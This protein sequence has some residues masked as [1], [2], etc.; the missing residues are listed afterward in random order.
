MTLCFLAALSAPLV[1]SSCKHG[2]AH[3]SKTYHGVGVIDSV[4]QNLHTVNID[5]EE[6]KDYM[7]AMNMLY[8]VR[9]KIS[10]EDFKHGDHVEFTIQDGDS[11]ATVTEMKKQSGSKPIGKTLLAP[12]RGERPI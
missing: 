12:L 8:K 5:H 11:G 10:L 2:A 3:I 4:D 9:K 6:I 1:A 7:P